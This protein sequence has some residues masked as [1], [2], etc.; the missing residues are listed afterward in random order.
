MR[1]KWQREMRGDQAAMIGIVIIGR[2][3][4]LIRQG[5][6]KGKTGA[7][8]RKD[9]LLHWRVLAR[10]LPNK[11]AVFRLGAGIIPRWIGTR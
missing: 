10:D 11:G 8:S 5:A 3:S 1:S 7:E 6:R 4:E 9:E 2:D